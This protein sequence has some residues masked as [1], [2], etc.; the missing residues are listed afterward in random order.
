MTKKVQVDEVHRTGERIALLLDAWWQDEPRA[1]SAAGVFAFPAAWQVDGFVR[2]VDHAPPVVEVMAI[3]AEAPPTMAVLRELNDLNQAATFVRFHC[4]E[5]QLVWATRAFIVSH[6]VD[7]D[8]R[9]AIDQVRHSVTRFGAM[10][11]ALG[12]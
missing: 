4:D 5:D 9:T 3:V 8:L 10:L 11:R 6:T 1:T 7:A 12:S 2:V